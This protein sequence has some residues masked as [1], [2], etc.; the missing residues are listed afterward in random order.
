MK[1][2]KTRVMMLSL[3]PSYTGTRNSGHLSHVHESSGSF[4][5]VIVRYL[6]AKNWTSLRNSCL[7]RLFVCACPGPRSQGSIFS[8]D[9][10]VATMLLPM[11]F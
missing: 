5:V 9:S 4:C 8:D 10:E 3:I 11:L 6:H 2:I 1:R 7:S